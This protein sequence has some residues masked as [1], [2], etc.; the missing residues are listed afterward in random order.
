MESTKD[1]VAEEQRG[2]RPDKG[3]EDQIFVLKQKRKEV[4]VCGVPEIRGTGKS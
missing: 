3:C 1:E 2:F 4:C